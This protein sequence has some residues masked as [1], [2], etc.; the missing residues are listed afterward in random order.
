MTTIPHSLNAI[1]R[2]IDMAEMIKEVAPLVN[3]SKSF[4]DGVIAGIRWMMG[5]L[6]SPCEDAVEEIN[7]V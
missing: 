5:Q 6:P 7:N 4:E 3:E 1:E 2:E